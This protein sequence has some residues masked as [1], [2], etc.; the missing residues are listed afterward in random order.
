MLKRLFDI[1]FSFLGLVALGPILLWLAWR[2]KSEDDG[3]VFYRGD[4]HHFLRM[5]I[6]RIN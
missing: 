4:S 1:T 3:Q 6:Q 5:I 2:I